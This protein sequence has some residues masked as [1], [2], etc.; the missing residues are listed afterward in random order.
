MFVNHISEQQQ[1]YQQPIPMAAARHKYWQD[2][3]ETVQREWRR[4]EQ[5][6]RGEENKV[7][8]GLTKDIR[9]VIEILGTKAVE[10]R[11]KKNIGEK[12]KNS[13]GN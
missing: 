7:L 4:R 3:T 11:E 1:Q 8:E 9:K 2:R 10:E 13:K 12:K 5:E 6:R